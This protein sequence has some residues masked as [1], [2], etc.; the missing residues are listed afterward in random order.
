MPIRGSHEML[1]KRPVPPSEPERRTMFHFV[2][3][4]PSR[5]RSGFAEKRTESVIE[6][7]SVERGARSNRFTSAEGFAKI[8]A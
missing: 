7:L 4:N 2:R 6:T 3:R 1:E 8:L 5:Q